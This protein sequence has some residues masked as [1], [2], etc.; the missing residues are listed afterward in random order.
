MQVNDMNIDRT[1]KI[2]EIKL[3]IADLTA[4]Q[5]DLQYKDFWSYQDRIRNKDIEIELENL[6]KRLESLNAS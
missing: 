6:S 5:R 2:T 4:E 1:K 3:K